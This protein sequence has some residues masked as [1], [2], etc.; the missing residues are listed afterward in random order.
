MSKKIKALIKK[1]KFNL[2]NREAMIFELKR[3]RREAT[4]SDVPV[5]VRFLLRKQGIFCD[6]SV[7]GDSY[8]TFYTPLLENDFDSILYKDFLKYSPNELTITKEA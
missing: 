8:L 4:F 5:H 2:L 3:G 1:I 7:I 6:K